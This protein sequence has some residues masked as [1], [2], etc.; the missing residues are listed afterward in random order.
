MSKI[1]KY[2]NDNENNC[3]KDDLL[4]LK[5]T[6]ML[7]RQPQNFNDEYIDARVSND[8][9]NFLL[10]LQ[11]NK[12]L[13]KIATENNLEH[14]IN[15]LSFKE[16]QH[17][18]SLTENEEN[19]IEKDDSIKLEKI[20]EFLH[21]NSKRQNELIKN[22]EY[23][24]LYKSADDVKNNFNTLNDMTDRNKPLIKIMCLLILDFAKDNIVK[25]FIERIYKSYKG[26]INNEVRY[27]DIPVFN[28]SLKEIVSRLHKT[29]NE[30]LKN[31]IKNNPD[32]KIPNN[33]KITTNIFNPEKKSYLENSKEIED[34]DVREALDEINEIYDMKE[35]ENKFKKL[36]IGSIKILEKKKQRY[37]KIAR[38]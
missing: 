25:K 36:N 13:I 7:L 29:T 35:I 12:K 34:K 31:N 10:K 18:N 8:C 21:L 3:T 22:S 16:R 4:E 20:I 14:I 26:S 33:I 1:N 2:Y 28:D 37:V 19:Y 5:T 6:L 24:N 30:L 32:N 23:L 38:K 9:R 15:Y 11:A 27:L 17:S